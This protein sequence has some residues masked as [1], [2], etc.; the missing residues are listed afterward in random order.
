MKSGKERH[1]NRPPRA[2]LIK[3]R[4]SAFGRRLRKHGAKDQRGRH[5]S[6]RHGSWGNRD[7]IKPAHKTAGH[8]FRIGERDNAG[9]THGETLIQFYKAL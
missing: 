2:D 8:D 7:G 4:A 9:V 6:S 1:P 5:G 3:L